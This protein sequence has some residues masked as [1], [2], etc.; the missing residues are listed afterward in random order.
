MGLQ[1]ALSTSLRGGLARI[2]CTNTT[3]IATGSVSGGYSSLF[4]MISHDS[5]Q[6]W[7]EVKN[8]SGVSQKNKLRIDDISCTGENCVAAG[9]YIGNNQYVPILLVSHNKGDSW[10]AVDK[11]PNA[12]AYGSFSNV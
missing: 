5:G 9:D 1:K 4:L 10:S 3:C 7:T 6:S 8:I 2:N 11:I 12:P